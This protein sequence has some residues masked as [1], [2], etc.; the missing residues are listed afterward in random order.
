MRDRERERGRE[1][2]KREK[3][4]RMTEREREKKKREREIPNHKVGCQC[5]LEGHDPYC[6]LLWVSVAHCEKSKVG[7]AGE[8]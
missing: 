1:K 7:V 5:V 4:H 6:E 8:A 2:K 3:K